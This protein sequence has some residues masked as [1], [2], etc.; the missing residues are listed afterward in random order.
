VS[1]PGL[2]KGEFYRFLADAFKMNRQFKTK[3]EFLVSFIHFLNKAHGSRKKVLLIIDESQRLSID[4][5]EEIR[6]LSNI[7][8]HDTRLLNIFLVGQNELNDTL[9]DPACRALSQRISNLYFIKSLKKKEVAEYINF[10]LETAGAKSKIFSAA[11]IREVISHTKCNPRLI[12]LLC[13]HALLTG[14]VKNKTRI[15]AKTVKECAKE[16]R[17]AERTRKRRVAAVGPAEPRAA[18]PFLG[19]LGWKIVSLLGVAFMLLLAVST[20]LYYTRDLPEARQRT[21]NTLSADGGPATGVRSEARQPAS[22]ASASTPRPVPSDA[23]GDTAAS[24]PPAGE[25]TAAAGSKAPEGPKDVVTAAGNTQTASPA[26]PARPP[27]P[28]QPVVVRF[29]ENSNELSSSG[30]RELAPIVE[31]YAHY[32]DAQIIIRGYTDSTGPV[33]Y[34]KRL[35]KFRADIVKSYFVGQGIDPERISALGLGPENPIAANSSPDGRRAN[36][37]VEVTFER[38]SS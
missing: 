27:L 15:D 29:A 9:M 11:A 30:Y 28:E 19:R 32:P 35:S 31:L 2:D 38:P 14:Y 13:D 18:I 24:A 20:Y 3:G 8:R 6:L 33:D 7:E 26:P 37:R 25:L 17:I 23:S 12:N 36:R 5:L 34:N 4:M 16:L 21:E 1:D 22:E 10:R